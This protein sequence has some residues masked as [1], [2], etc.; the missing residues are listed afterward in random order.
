MYAW[1]FR[2]NCV[3]S[4]LA[5]AGSCAAFAISGFA[6]L[7]GFTARC[8]QAQLRGLVVDSVGAQPIAVATVNVG[9]AAASPTSAPVAKVRTAEDG[10]FRVDGLRPGRY[11]V[12][13]RALGFAHRGYDITVGADRAPVDVGRIALSRVATTLDKVEVQEEERAITLAP[14]RNSYSTK[15]LSA[16]SSGGT[17][18]DVLRAVPAVE[19]DGDNNVALRGNAN[20]VVQINGRPSPLRGQQLGNYLAQLPANLLARVEVATNPSS[21]N[22]PDGGAGIINLVL[23]QRADLGRSGGL[24]FGTATTGLASLSGTLAR[25]QGS[26][27]ESAS[28]SIFRERRPTD[29]YVD[30]LGPPGSTSTALLA[31]TDG[32]TEPLYVTFTLRGERKIGSRQTLAADAVLSGG[33]FRSGTDAAYTA[34]DGGGDLAARFL[35]RTAIQNGSVSGDYALAWRRTT[36]PVRNHGSVEIRF[37]ESQNRSRNL[38]GVIPIDG[39]AGVF[40][41][42]AA[43]DASASRI[44]TWRLQTDWTHPLLKLS[45]VEFGAVGI[46]RR[47]ASSFERTLAD[48]TLLP[49][50]TANNTLAYRE[51]VVAAYGVLSGR[52]RRFELQGGLRLEGAATRFDLV[53][54]DTVLGTID[55]GGRTRFDNRYRSVFPSGTVSYRIDP[56]TQIKATYARRISRPDPMQ[57]NPTPWRQDALNVFQGN[58]A[59]RPEYTDAW[60]LGY[61]VTRKWGFVQLSP[62]FRRTPDAIRYVRLVDSAGV[63]RGTFANVAINRSW[64][65]DLNLSVR[66]GRLT[67]FGGASGFRSRTDAPGLAEAF[68]IS[69]VGW[70][71]RGNATWRL[72]KL[73]DVQAFTFYRP[74]MLTESGLQRAFATTN[75]ALQRKLRGD[76]ATLTLRA[77]DPFNTMAWGIR[78]TTGEVVQATG[79]RLGARAL[80][81]TFNY[82]FGQPPRMRPSRDEGSMVP[83]GMPGTGSPPA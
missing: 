73:L 79:L 22:D 60:E 75:L 21:K 61:Q 30:R 28:I 77:V 83:A 38:L 16:A 5:V 31:T 58:P 33:R 42:R 46:A 41:V 65:T 71:A 59:L 26:S 7:G 18:I 13:V 62:Y 49:D 37:N 32:Y 43:R 27:T 9:D 10:T 25:Q 2:C 81:V 70:T 82:S 56:A 4:S 14:D 76:R 52:A 51:H 48:T 19:V 54:L 80:G 44:P 66:A 6:S 24:T 47:S 3:Q 63:A 72:T 35:Q 20:V 78:T 39:D 74:S 23:Q 36:D 68:S 12:L 34:L 15:Q 64:G 45:K 1:L 69:A 29:G 11:R 17:A 67:Y 8:A 50:G 57:L 53:A 55:F 40:G